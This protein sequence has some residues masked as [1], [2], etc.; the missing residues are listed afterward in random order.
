MEDL[1]TDDGLYGDL[2]TGLESLAKEQN[3][4]ET[5][6]SL[7]ESQQ[8]NEY[9]DIQTQDDSQ[10]ENMTTPGNTPD[11]SNE[12]DSEEPETNTEVTNEEEIQTDSQEEFSF[13]G[14]TNVLS[15]Y[16]VTQELTEEQQQELAELEGEQQLEKYLQF[17]NENTEA[18]IESKAAKLIDESIG[19]LPEKTRAI[20]DMV[21]RG[22]DETEAIKLAIEQNALAA[23]KEQDLSGNVNLQKETIANYLR[24]TGLPEEEITERIEFYEAKD[25][26]ESNAKSA[27]SNQQKALAEQEKIKE[28]KAQEEYQRQQQQLELTRKEYK[29]LIDSQ[30]EIIPGMKITKKTKDAVFESLF[31]PIKTDKGMTTA[32]RIARDKD[33][34]AFDVKLAYLEHLGLFNNNKKAWDSILKLGG[35]KQVNTI[36]KQMKSG[37]KAGKYTNSNGQSSGLLD[38]LKQHFPKK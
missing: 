16:G 27:L 19:S 37:P 4:R 23:I 31:K 5:T 12:D 34:M 6:S 22:I 7:T 24:S 30:D 18:A 8:S 20:I 10:L 36:M 38:A 35:T 21:S 33:P 26:L 15:Q 3:E 29:N 13:D 32:I 28:A 9:S 1:I 11:I 17:Q 25:K 2:V 14:I